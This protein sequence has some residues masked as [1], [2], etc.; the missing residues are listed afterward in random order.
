MNVVVSVV[1]SCIA[2]SAC[3]HPSYVAPA[4]S[5]KGD[6]PDGWIC[7]L[8]RVC[9]LPAGIDGGTTGSDSAVATGQDAGFCYG[10]G[11]VSVCLA[12]APSQP[13]MTTDLTAIDTD[14]SL[15]CAATLG[16]GEYCVIA[17]TTVAIDGVLRATGRRPL[18]LLASDS[19]TTSSM[20][21]VGSHRSSPDRVG[22]GADH[23]ACSG[24]TGPTGGGGG[25]GGSFVGIGGAGG[26]SATSGTSS[27]GTSGAAAIAVTALRGGCTGQ[28][29]DGSD[30]GL[31]GHGGGAVA[32]IAG[33]SIVLHAEIDAGGE[34]GSAGTGLTSGGAGGGAG[35]MIVLDA[36]TIS[37]SS[38]LVANGGGGGEGSEVSIAGR[39]GADATAV[40]AAPGGSG[41]T[42]Q[43]GD[44]GAGSSQASSASG[45]AGGAGT[46][47]TGTSHGAGGGGGGGAGLIVAPAWASLGG[48][49]SPAPTH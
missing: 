4:C 15:L 25:A 34:G 33:S 5:P 26:P 2:L 18:V 37:S 19:I 27:G 36:P 24:G 13:F 39:N 20:I 29:G 11:L 38:A 12:A 41:L 21:D 16:A 3:F 31:A 9:E 44:G 1:L 46:T 40:T 47:G 6:C 10:T 45:G 28:G 30:G 49:T 43:G 35:G 48:A 32:L 7:N 8:Q 42:G 14:S 23:A 17:G 22:A